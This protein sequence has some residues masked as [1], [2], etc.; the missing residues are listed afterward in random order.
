MPTKIKPDDRLII[1]S[2][3]GVQ[4][5]RGT[6]LQRPIGAL[7]GTIR[8]NVTTSTLEL[9]TGGTD[10]WESISGSSIGSVYDPSTI[11]A[12]NLGSITTTPNDYIDA[13][14]SVIHPLNLDLGSEGPL[15]SINLGSLVWLD[16]DT[17]Q[18]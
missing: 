9:R 8:Y 15:V 18:P 10:H 16:L 6:T 5:P 1:D 4:L 12:G 2:R 7:A 11:L 13:F 14:G 3:D 17:N